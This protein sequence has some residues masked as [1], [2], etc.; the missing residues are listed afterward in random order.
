M[1][2]HDL[3]HAGARPSKVLRD[4][5]YFFCFGRFWVRILMMG[6]GAMGSCVG[7]FMAMGGHGVTLVGRSAHMAAIR[8]EGLCISGIWGEHRVMGLDTCTDVGELG[9]GEFDVV[10]IAVKSYDTVASVAAVAPL[11]GED[12]LVCSYQN[13]LGNAETIA[14]SVGWARTVGVR[15]IYG[16]RCD[17]PGCVAVTVIA[18]PTAL[19]VYEGG[20][21]AARV[22]ALV[23]TMA[24]AGLPTVY[25]D[26][27]EAVLWSKM[28]YNCA[29]NPLSA[30]L[31]VPY[32]GLAETVGTRAMMEEVIRELYSVGEALGVSLAPDSVDAYIAH[33]YED[34]LPPTAAH[35]AS[36]RTDF[37]G[38]RRT[39]IDALN[40]A[41]VGYGLEKGVACPTNALLVRLVHAREFEFGVRGLE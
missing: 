8:A 14:A 35:Y 41:I 31:D 2:L 1:L 40:G 25:S 34:L 30:I 28:A 26:S 29:L 19:G 6:A 27:I 15:A 9:G 38:K 16:V 11:V 13:G 3:E 17:A 33:F 22:E 7:G 18:N 36:M 4:R 10:F 12:T 24:A 5:K 32:G 20:P 21:S 23:A 39:E 37:L